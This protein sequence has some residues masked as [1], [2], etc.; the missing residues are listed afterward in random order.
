MPLELFVI[1]VKKK[2][3]SASG[4]VPG[5][6]QRRGRL[7]SLIWL[8]Q[9]LTG[10]QG[11]TAQRRQLTQTGELEDR[12]PSGIKV[13]S[14]KDKWEYSLMEGVRSG[15]GRSEFMSEKHYG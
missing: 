2:A 12:L 14:R 7:F 1:S 8:C 9:R 13:E 5:L 4:N 11:L 10:T 6:A 3:Y 15:A